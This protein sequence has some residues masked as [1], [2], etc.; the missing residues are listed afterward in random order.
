MK[1]IRVGF[2]SD[3]DVSERDVTQISY[4]DIRVTAWGGGCYSG[5]TPDPSSL[6]V[7]PSLNNPE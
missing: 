4:K 1:L 3:V 6:H 5:L 2:M 7:S